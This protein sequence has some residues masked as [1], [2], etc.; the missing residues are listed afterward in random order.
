MITGYLFLFI[1][2]SFSNG[3]YNDT[4][5]FNIDIGRNQNIR[6]GPFM[7]FCVKNTKGPSEITEKV[8]VQNANLQNSMRILGL[9]PKNEVSLPLVRKF[10]L[11]LCN[12][13]IFLF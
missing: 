1:I 2:I 8:G 6:D 10:G 12:K 7:F 3:I 9:C 5:E 11:K 4:D 13:P